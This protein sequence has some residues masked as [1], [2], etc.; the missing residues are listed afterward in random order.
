MD[1]AFVPSSAPEQGVYIS[2]LVLYNA[3]WDTRRQCVTLPCTG[4]RQL[5]LIWLKFLDMM[6]EPSAKDE[7]DEDEIQIFACPLVCYHDSEDKSNIS[8]IIL[9]FAYPPVSQRRL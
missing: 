2:G 5:P 4:T 9:I 3:F 6:A 1:N 8:P 7:F